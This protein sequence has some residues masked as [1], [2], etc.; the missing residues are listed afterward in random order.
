MEEQ[1]TARLFETE[2]QAAAKLTKA[3]AKADARFNALKAKA[4]KKISAAKTAAKASSAESRGDKKAESISESVA[5]IV[6]KYKKERARR[7]EMEKMLDEA[8]NHRSELSKQIK[9][10]QHHISTDATG[11]N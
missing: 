6:H 10:L 3:L 7:I 5:K 11:S 8:E 1:A 2:E 4:E 9:D